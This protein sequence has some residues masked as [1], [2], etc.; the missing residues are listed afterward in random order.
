MYKEAW[1][2]ISDAIETV[3]SW[4]RVSVSWNTHRK[5]ISFACWVNVQELPLVGR[6]G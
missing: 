5:L 4:S 6:V 1:P 2:R 3:S